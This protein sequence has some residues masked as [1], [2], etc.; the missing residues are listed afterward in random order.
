MIVMYSIKKTAE[1]FIVEEITP[2]DKIL[3][4]GSSPAFDE[5]SKGEHLVCFL[6]K[7]NW[8][9]LLLIN[10]IA[11]K[12]HVSRKRIGYAGMKD[13]KAWTTQR[14]SIWNAKPED[15][16]KISIRDARILP[17]Y[18]SDDRVEL[19][20]LL[21]NRFTLKVF[22]DKPPREEKRI[23]NFFGVQRFGGVRP[24][25]HLVGKEIVKGNFKEAV[26]I[27]LTKVFEKE[28]EEAKQA[29]KKLVEEEDFKKA[30]QYF[31][32]GL[33]F[34]RMMLA[35]LSQHPN[36]FIGALR[37]LP[38]FLKIMFVHAYQSYLFNK[39]LERVI[40]KELELE[41]GPLYG[42]EL[43][44]ENELEEEILREE[45]LKQSDFRIKSMP[46]ASSKGKRRK[47]FI[48]LTDF[49]IIG[50]GEE[51]SKHYYVLRFSLPKGCYATTVVDWLFGN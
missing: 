29:R 17:L 40:E 27:Y 41:E 5:K 38:R 47:L 37:K 2:E 18:H 51:C 19:G 48:E 4:V 28:S 35:H 43:E 11:K 32:K 8:D 34:E 12:L 9:N 14:I 23:P 42:Y 1:D 20:D 45:G 46:E 25:T 33:K 22:S 26:M 44:P 6:E 31:P 49:E 13:K 36:D 39:F 10:K 21:G 50:E 16:E 30:L 7:K 15:L 3:E 24:I